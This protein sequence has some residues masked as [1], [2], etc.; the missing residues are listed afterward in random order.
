MMT[1]MNDTI[2]A[3]KQVIEAFQR[4]SDYDYSR[5]LVGNNSTNYF[6]ELMRRF[7]DWL[8]QGESD[9]NTVLN[10]KWLWWVL[11]ILFALLLVWLFWRVRFKLFVKE[12]KDD[13][14]FDV[15]LDDIHELDY[16]SLIADAKSQ[17]NHLQVCRLLYLRA[18]K[19]VSDAGLVQWQ[20]YKTPS[21]YSREWNDGD[22]RVMTNH[23]LRV[24][25]GKFDADQSLAQEMEHLGELVEQRAQAHIQATQKN[26][27]QSETAPQDEEKGGEA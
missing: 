26:E 5:E 7:Y 6:D 14:D 8:Y 2:V 21:Q 12:E 20:R 19:N 23:F 27:Q 4:N 13:A 18:L 17:G 22:F 1:T 11:G 3:N 15:L 10:Y 9:V 24:R 16:D 25:Y